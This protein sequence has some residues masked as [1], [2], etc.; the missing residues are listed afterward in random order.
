MFVGTRELNLAQI[1]LRRCSSDLLRKD[2]FF[3]FEEKKIFKNGQ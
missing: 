2:N 3:F 1:L